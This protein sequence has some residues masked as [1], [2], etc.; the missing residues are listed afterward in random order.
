[1]NLQ[2]LWIRGAGGKCSLR[3]DGV[4]TF[5]FFG[6]CGTLKKPGESLKLDDVRCFEA[7]TVT[8]R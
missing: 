1:M 5:F 8:G 6:Q 7:G 2:N 4:V 3:G